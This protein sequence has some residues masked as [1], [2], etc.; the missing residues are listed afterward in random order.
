MF[1]FPDNQ[2]QNNVTK[3]ESFPFPQMEDCVDSV[4]CA[5]YVSK[6]NLLK[7]VSQVPLTACAQEISSAVNQLKKTN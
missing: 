5:S 4:G 3:L 1:S 7:G 6:F 2:N